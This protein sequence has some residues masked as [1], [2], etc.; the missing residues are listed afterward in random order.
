M[1]YVTL[2]SVVIRFLDFRT[3]TYENDVT[4]FFQKIFPKQLRF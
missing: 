2:S 1:F 4:A 3:F